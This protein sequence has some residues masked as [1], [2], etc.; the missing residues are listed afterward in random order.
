MSDA[1]PALAPALL[2]GLGGMMIG[3]RVRRAYRTPVTTADRPC[4]RRFWTYR[5]A[6]ESVAAQHERAQESDRGRD[7]GVMADTLAGKTSFGVHMSRSARTAGC[8][9]G[10][11][12]L[13]RPTRP[14]RCW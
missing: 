9:G 12:G 1:H 10:G 6:E 4:N 2:G 13:L 8:R 5:S 11:R 3:E 7:T 14:S